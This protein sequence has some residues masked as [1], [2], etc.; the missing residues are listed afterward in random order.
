M[1][2]TLIFLQIL[3]YPDKFITLYLES[4]ACRDRAKKCLFSFSLT[5]AVSTVFILIIIRVSPFMHEQ[6]S[7]AT[8]RK[9]EK[10]AFY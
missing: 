2:L 5:I 7:I 6:H 9:K 3:N 8:W 1:E 10:K 4:N